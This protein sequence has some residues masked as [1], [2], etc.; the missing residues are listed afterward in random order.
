LGACLTCAPGR[1]DSRREG[2][3]HR[4][5]GKLDKLCPRCRQIMPLT[6]CASTALDAACE[7]CREGL[8]VSPRPGIA[9][10]WPVTGPQPCRTQPRT[11]HTAVDATNPDESP[12]C[13]A[14]R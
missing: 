4:S 1:A 7:N 11:P 8:L 10:C 3:P 2:S 12:A 5:D 14:A 6:A 13:S 9:N